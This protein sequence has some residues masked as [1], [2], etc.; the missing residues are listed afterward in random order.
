VKDTG[1][2]I[3]DPE[4]SRVLERFYR[5]AGDTSDGFGLGLAIAAKATETLGGTIAVGSVEGAG[6]TVELTFPEHGR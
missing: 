5:G 6:T 4:Q 2:G 3:A 1:Q